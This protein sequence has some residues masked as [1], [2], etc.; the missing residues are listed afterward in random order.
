MT[1]VAVIRGS[2]ALPLSG[3]DAAE[4]RDL[5]TPWGDPSGE[6]VEFNS[7]TTKVLLLNRHGAGHRPPPP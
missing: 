5:S 6:I 3:A 7:G 1:C 4:A 2:A